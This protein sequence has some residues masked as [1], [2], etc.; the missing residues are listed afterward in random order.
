MTLKSNPLSEKQLLALNELIKEIT[1]EQIIWLS[2]YL[3][4]KMSGLPAG[5]VAKSTVSVS[6]GGQVE[7]GKLTVLYGT[8]TGNSKELAEKLAVKAGFKNISANVVSMYDFNY[9]KLKE[10]E[11][12]AIIVSTHGEGDPPDM[13]DDFYKYLTGKRAPKLE[14]L[15]YSVLALGDKSYKYFC[16]TGEEIDKTCKN[17]G[18]YRVAPLVKCDDD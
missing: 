5:N 15:N 3:E 2:G 17:Q 8:E 14:K 6:T 10:E 4:G 7:L 16:K 18:A 1:P 9:K 12:I 11:N 13:A